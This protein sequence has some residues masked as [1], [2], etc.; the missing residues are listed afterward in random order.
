MAAPITITHCTRSPEL[1]ATACQGGPTAVAQ[2][3]CAARRS[4]IYIPEYVSP[5]GLCQ[6]LEPVA[7]RHERRFGAG[8]EGHKKA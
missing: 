5:R 1:D 3:P 8:W 2:Q 7:E 6:I 4:A